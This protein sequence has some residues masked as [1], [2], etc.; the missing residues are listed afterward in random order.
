[1]RVF[2]SVCAQAL[3][4][5]FAGLVGVVFG[6]GLGSLVANTCRIVSQL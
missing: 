1:M 2:K 3:V 6:L 4:W 5:A